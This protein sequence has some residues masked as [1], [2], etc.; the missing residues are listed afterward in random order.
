VRTETIRAATAMETIK[1]LAHVLGEVLE[2]GIA[3]PEDTLYFA[4]STYGLGHRSLVS[5][6]SDPDFE[7]TEALKE[8]VFSPGEDVRTIVEPLVPLEGMPEKDFAGLVTCLLDAVRSLDLVVDNG[9]CLYPVDLDRDALAIFISK[10]YLERPLD[11][12][13]TAALEASFPVASVM[14]SRVLMRTRNDLFGEHKRTFMCRFIARSE[15]YQDR[16]RDLLGIVLAALAEIDDTRPIESYL[17]Q[18]RRGL[19]SRLREIR[20][21]HGKRDQYSMEYLMMQRFRIP[22]E[23]EEEVLG[24]LF[25]LSTVT[26]LIL[27]LPPDPTVR[28]ES[29]DLGAFGADINIPLLIKRLS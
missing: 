29:E 15:P 25:L 9:A 28:I 19:I 6:L 21:F 22:P 18:K 4:E 8:L 26:D 27:G 7:G 3:V 20:H 12:R 24:R 13:V 17:L 14:S 5:A 2:R 23:S 1:N 11:A 10:L 16:F